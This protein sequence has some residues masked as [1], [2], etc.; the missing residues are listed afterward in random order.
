LLD[1]DFPAPPPVGATVPVSRNPGFAVVGPYAD[2]IKIISVNSARLVTRP[3]MDFMTAGQCRIGFFYVGCVAKFRENGQPI[4]DF[5]AGSAKGITAF[6]EMTAA[7]DTVSF[8]TSV[9]DDYE[10]YVVL[11]KCVD[12]N[13]AEGVFCFSGLK[14]NGQIDRS[15]A[16]NGQRIISNLPWPILN[17]ANPPRL[18]RQADGKMVLAYGCRLGGNASFACLA[19]Y[20]NDGTPDNSFKGPAGSTTGAFFLPLTTETS[21]DVFADITIDSDGNFLVTG[22]CG[23]GEF[24]TKF[25]AARLNGG[26]YNLDILGLGNVFSAYNVPNALLATRYLFGFR[27]FALNEG[28]AFPPFAERNN[29]YKMESYLAFLSKKPSDPNRCWLGISNG[30]QPRPLVDGLLYLRAALGLN[31]VALTG[32][33]TFP[34]DATRTDATV[35]RNYLT[36]ECALPQ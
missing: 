34:P 5:G 12:P 19:R 28:I 23:Y 7:Y 17:A 6:L 11:G 1:G 31:G 16:A 36:N 32:G 3:T 35:I 18:I 20:N 29:Y 27:G 14:A 2:G 10:R 13:V 30:T 4:I 25:C 22:T 24:S 8:P 26:T 9:F 15:W 21:R 33:I